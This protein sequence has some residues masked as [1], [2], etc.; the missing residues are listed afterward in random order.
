MDAVKSEIAWLLTDEVQ[1][2]GLTDVREID[3][4][5]SMAEHIPG[6]LI[7]LKLGFQTISAFIEK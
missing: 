4:L 7:N 5:K 1:L 6:D 2:G 3:F